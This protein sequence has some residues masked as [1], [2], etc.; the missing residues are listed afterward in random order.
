MKRN[1]TV[2][3]SCLMVIFA[4]TA[5]QAMAVDVYSE[6]AY[7]DTDNDVQVCIYADIDGSEALR[8][9]GVKLVYN[10]GELTFDATKSTK[11]EEVWYLGDGTNNEQYRDPEDVEDGQGRAVVI[12][13]GKLDTNTGMAGVK[14]SGDRVLLGTV[15]FTRDSGSGHLANSLTLAIGKV[16]PYANFVKGSEEGDVLDGSVN[17]GAVDVYK[18]GDADKNGT[19][20]A[21]DILYVKNSMIPV[22]GYTC[23]ADGDRN[24]V[25]DAM[26]ILWI[27]SNMD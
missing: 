24:D 3:F 5:G 15:W 8:S 9:F 1:L 6:G 11:N 27:K 16:T 19:V 25:V 2:F 23:F 20:D 7:S 18:R 13:G 26:D 4:F 22:D 12:I 14:V 21:M 17:F 10:P